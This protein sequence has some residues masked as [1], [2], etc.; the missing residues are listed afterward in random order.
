M[1]ALGRTSGHRAV[2]NIKDADGRDKPGHQNANARW[3]LHPHRHQHV[4]RAFCVLIL[5][6]GR[7]TR[8]G[9]LEHGNFALDLSGYIGR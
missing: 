9:E 6:Q 4:E 3:W 5:D 2:P 1:P 8:I 7:R